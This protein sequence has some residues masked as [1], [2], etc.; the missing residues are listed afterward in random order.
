M[1]IATKKTFSEFLQENKAITAEGYVKI[2][3]WSKAEAD[4]MRYACSPDINQAPARE[5]KLSNSEIYEKDADAITRL[6][7][8]GMLSDNEATKARRK[9]LKLIERERVSRKASTC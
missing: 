8:R 9:L 6:N 2:D 4:Y 1:K 3:A 5:H 7:I